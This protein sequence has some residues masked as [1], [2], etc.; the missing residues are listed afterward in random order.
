MTELVGLGYYNL[1]LG[2]REDDLPFFI[3]ILVLELSVVNP[4]EFFLVFH[5]H[6]ILKEL[7]LS[8][9]LSLLSSYKIEVLVV[10]RFL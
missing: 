6:A 2:M 8:R 7:E 10:P 5:G 4:P 1:R 9:F 3:K